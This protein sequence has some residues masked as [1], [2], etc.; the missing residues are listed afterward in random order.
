HNLP[1]SHLAAPANEKL[2]DLSLVRL[3]SGGDEEF[4]LKMIDLFIKTM[5][6]SLQLLQESVKN[7]Q[8]DDAGKA[9]HKM[10]STIDAIGISSLKN[11]IRQIENYS[12]QRQSPDEINRL[13]KI[14]EE[15]LLKCIESMKKDFNLN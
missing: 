5:P 4:V 1:T 6:D 9:A 3:L 2:Y 8:W 7:E 11:N 12:K 13:V 10:K 15:V 14:A